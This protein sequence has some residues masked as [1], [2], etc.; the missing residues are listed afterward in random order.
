MNY[1]QLGLEYQV[2][3]CQ[4]LFNIALCHL[5]MGNTRQGV[6]ALDRAFRAIPPEGKNYFNIGNYWQHK[7]LVEPK[8][9]TVV[10]S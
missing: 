3:E 1:K 5:Q 7:R 9:I 8:V 6:K 10:L 2:L 4:T